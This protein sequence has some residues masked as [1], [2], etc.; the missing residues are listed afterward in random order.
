MSSPTFVVT[1][2][3]LWSTFWTNS[4]VNALSAYFSFVTKSATFEI[5][6]FFK[7]SYFTCTVKHEIP[8]LKILIKKFQKKNYF[9]FIFELYH[10]Y[11]TA[12]ALRCFIDID[13][14]HHIWHWIVTL[15]VNFSM[16]IFLIVSTR[17]CSFWRPSRFCAVFLLQRALPA[18]ENKHVTKNRIYFWNFIFDQKFYFWSKILFLTKNFVFDEKF[19][20]WR[21]LLFLKKHFIFDE[22]FYFWRNILFLTKILLLTKN[23]TLTEKNKNC[24]FD[25]NNFFCL[26][27]FLI[28]DQKC[29]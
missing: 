23:F 5:T 26:S 22:N 17:V 18:A 21:K 3:W 8:K 12:L 1:L 9:T 7:S 29:L 11:E 14:F 4:S 10:K 27:K 25:Q 2:S 6:S 28:V 20:L 16:I 24:I 19:Y 13:N 15:K